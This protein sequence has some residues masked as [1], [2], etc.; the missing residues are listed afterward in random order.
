MNGIDQKG[1]NLVV[2]QN[3][4]V[5]LLLFLTVEGSDTFQTG[6]FETVSQ[7]KD[8]GWVKTVFGEVQLS[9]TKSRIV[10]SKN[11]TPP[12]IPESL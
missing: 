10:V 5:L 3:T 12:L 1:P 4:S 8:S 2:G 6:C 11:A 7:H 9:V